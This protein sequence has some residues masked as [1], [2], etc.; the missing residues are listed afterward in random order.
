[1]CGQSPAA[2][3]SLRRPPTC[4]KPAAHRSHTRLATGAG[5]YARVGEYRQCPRGPV[6]GKQPG[7]PGGPTR[8]PSASAAV[9]PSAHVC[10][11]NQ[12]HDVPSGSPLSP[13]LP[14]LALSAVNASVGGRS[15]VISAVLPL[16]VS[17]RPGEASWVDLDAYN[18]SVRYHVSITPR[19]RRRR[20]KDAQYRPALEPVGYHRL[21]TAG[22]A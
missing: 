13:S 16:C 22:V 21:L 5:D 14:P 20:Q 17:C 11:E 15:P 12:G 3:W 1:M 9:P 4:D 7:Q 2:N 18:S 19:D 6:R 10:L 8:L